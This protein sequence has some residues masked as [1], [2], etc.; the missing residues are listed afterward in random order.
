[1]HEV[2]LDGVF[3]RRHD[4]PHHHGSHIGNILRELMITP[5]QMWQI[6]E[7]VVEH[8]KILHEAFRGIWT[9][10]QPIIEAANEARMTIL[11]ALENGEITE[12]EARQQLMDLGQRMRS[13]IRSNLDNEPFL[14]AI[15]ESTRELFRKI[16]SVLLPEQQDLWDRWV[17]SL[18]GRCFG[19]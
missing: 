19:G 12:E 9:V 14:R 15:C 7:F 4:H 1:M 6:F 18:S 5:T 8:R 11:R 16:R 10:N 13:A 17:E 2:L 3:R